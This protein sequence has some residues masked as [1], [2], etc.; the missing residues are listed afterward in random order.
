[1]KL[2]LKLLLLLL[3]LVV[4]PLFTLGS[5]A[6]G[7]LGEVS[8]GKLL[9]NMHAALQHLQTH[10]G[11]QR[12][13]A[14]ANIE[15]FSRH[16]L[17]KKYVLTGDEDERYNLLQGP[18]LRVFSAFQEAFPQYYEIRILLPDGYE[19][20]RLTRADIDNHT[21]EEADSPLFKSLAATPDRVVS[22]VQ[23]NPDNG[24]VSLFI[25]KP[26]VLRDAAVDPV[27]TPPSLRGYLA[28]TADLGE[29]ESHVREDSIGTSGYLL[30]TDPDGAVVFAPS[31]IDTPAAVPQEL[32]AAVDRP[33][34]SLTE[35]SG[36]R[37]LLIRQS[38]V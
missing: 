22:L 28:I 36:Q 6:G 14:L 25:G 1:M 12:R 19:D 37:V 30:G 32:L 8:E 31:G 17:V 26:L 23:R 13:T 20:I 21:D 27:G 5:I 10:T 7:E 33:G 38:N 15:L 29:I 16:T 4:A 2:R 11:D 35:I 34:T 3:P 24:R 18:L 9:E